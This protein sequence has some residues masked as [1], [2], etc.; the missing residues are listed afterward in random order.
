MIRRN[1]KPFSLPIVAVLILW[2]ALNACAETATVD[3]R[4]WTF[5]VTDSEEATITGVSPK[6]GRLAI[7]SHLV[8]RRDPMVVVPVTRIGS[9]AFDDCV[10][11]T[12]VVIPEGVVDVGA[13]AFS[14]CTGLKSVSIPSSVA[15]IEYDAFYACIGLTDVYITDLANWC[16]VS[17]AGWDANPLYYAKHLVERETKRTSA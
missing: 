14:G 7:P 11:L 5:T 1:R 13:Y 10:E 15:T 16:A 2:T 4:T 3:G 12:S 8:A 17:F 6:T 9:W